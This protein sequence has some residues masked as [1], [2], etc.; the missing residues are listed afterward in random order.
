M[1]LKSCV[2]QSLFIGGDTSSRLRSQ[3]FKIASSVLGVALV[4]VIERHEG[5]PCELSRSQKL[6]ETLVCENFETGDCAVGM[7]QIKMIQKIN[8]KYLFLFLIQNI[9]LS[10]LI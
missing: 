9:Y 2:R 4:C 7:F 5:G 3:S 8:K 6:K 10:I 1:H